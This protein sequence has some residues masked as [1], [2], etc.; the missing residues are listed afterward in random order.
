LRRD[1]RLL[2]ALIL[3][4]AAL[5]AGIIQAWII[6]LYITAAVM[7]GGDYWDHFVGVFGGRSVANRPNSFC[8]DYCAPALPFIAGWIAISAFVGGVFAVLLAWLK[9]A[10]LSL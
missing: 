8:F 1:R 2:L 10:R 7:G 3:F 4:S 5:V 9:P 6:R